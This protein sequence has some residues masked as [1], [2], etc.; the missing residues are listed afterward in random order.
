MEPCQ[1][2]LYLFFD[3]T[4]NVRKLSL[5]I[6]KDNGLND[7]NTLFVIGG[8]FFKYNVNCVRLKK[9]FISFFDD[10]KVKLDGINNELKF[11][12]F[13]NGG[14]GEN[15]EKIKKLLNS[16]KLNI[17]FK[18]MLKN[19]VYIHYSSIDLIYYV[20]IDIV[21]SDQLIKEIE[22]YENRLPETI[23]LNSKV[24]EFH[25]GLKNLF[26]KVVRY[27]QLNFFVKLHELNFP[28]INKVDVEKLRI[29]VKEQL[30]NYLKN[31]KLTDIECDY[32]KPL[33]RILDANDFYFS[34]DAPKKE[35][36]LLDSL[37]FV[38]FSRLLDYP[39]SIHILDNEYDIQ[40]DLFNY[41]KKD[42]QS[43]N[44]GSVLGDLS[45]VKFNFS[46]SKKNFIL[47]IS[48]I[49]VGFIKE[50]YLFC[51]KSKVD[52]ENWKDMLEIMDKNFTEKQRNTL[53]MFCNIHQKSLLISNVNQL[54][55]IPLDSRKRFDELVCYFC[56]K[57][58]S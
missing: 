4:N 49:M 7:I 21:E 24:S 52:V 1:D 17:L 5:N 3:E 34:L 51:D 13:S 23:L 26:D 57:N 8:V 16:N 19:K 30:D 10:N 45:K 58:E 39:K 35:Y 44:K 43:F 11:S 15:V 31:N 55:T 20:F 18:W 38:Y 36:C 42:K 32:L 54:T 40:T 14:K 46:D 27:D 25:L 37:T 48:D 2:K 53:I 47:Q 22:L 33:K 56:D 41:K 9:S 12:E 6:N 28:D 50:I 29:L